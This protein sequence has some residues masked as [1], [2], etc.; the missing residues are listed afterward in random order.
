M[1]IVLTQSSV[2]YDVSTPLTLINMSNTYYK[3][4]Q[5]GH[6]SYLR[7]EIREHGIFK[8]RRF[9]ETALL[10]KIEECHKSFD[11]GR[12]SI[13]GQILS[14][15]YKSKL[16]NVFLGMAFIMKNFNLSK[17][18]SEEVLYN[19]YFALALSEDCFKNVKKV[20]G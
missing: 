5:E 14:K 9:W 3:E 17:Q 16:G 11:F 20:L 13:A 1:M 19:Y 8:K 10:W 18:N 6:K 12:K 4:A 7:E 2:N 15:S